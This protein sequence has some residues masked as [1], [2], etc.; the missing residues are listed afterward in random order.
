M[1]STNKKWL[2]LA[3]LQ[4]LLVLVYAASPSSLSRLEHA[5]QDWHARYIQPEHAFTDPRITLIDIDDASL[6]REGRWPWPRPQ[7]ADLLESIQ[8]HNPALIGIDIL[9]PDDSNQDRRLGKAL[10]ADNITTSLVWSSVRL[11]SNGNFP[12]VATCSNNCNQLPKAKSW[13]SNI[14]AL[15][16]IEQAHISP[17][18][19]K[20][21]IVRSL[22]P[23]VCKQNSCVETLAL[24]LSRQLLGSEAKYKLT[25]QANG[26]NL[27]SEDGI[28]NLPL[29]QDTRIRIPWYSPNAGRVPWVSAAKVLNNEIPPRFL[30]GRVLILGSSAV[31]LHDKISTPLTANYPAVEAHARLLQGILDQHY[32]YH[33]PYS[34]LITWLYALTTAL[35]VSGLLIRRRLFMAV[36]L[37]A[38]ANVGW[39]LFVSNA[40]K[41]GQIWP[42]LPVI[43]SPM[44]SMGLLLPWIMLDAQDARDILQHQFRHYVAPQVME[45]IQ[46]HPEYIIGA[47]PERSVMTVLFADLRSF[48]AYAE[49]TPP[50]QLAHILQEIM[51][52]LTET[53]H[54]HGGTVDKYI[55][56]AIMAFW[57]A[58]MADREHAAHGVAAAQDLCRTMERLS[59]TDGM[60][61]LQLSVGINSGVVVVGE[62]GSS[63]RRSYTLL[64]APVN[65]AA[66]LEGA[67]RKTCHPILVGSGTHALLP[68][69][70]WPEPI[71]LQLSS[72]NAPVTAWPLDADTTAKPS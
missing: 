38:C 48:S 24:S 23:L 43:L 67:T 56:D 13:I 53:I 65:L 25:P 64:G 63:H 31:G 36:L 61:P 34:E 32:W 3:A 66:H 45:R 41:E 4:A 19:D 40:L 28:L 49:N 20:D 50:E 37:V 46:K 58:P 22:Y 68:H 35:L 71:K 57:G 5:I 69:Y 42:Q 47:E 15:S 39:L 17:E 21:G 52:R 72:H 55:G 70:H 54:R 12:S 16:A 27:S 9:F 11:P 14:P 60:P 2:A 51:D 8:S 1:Q 59:Q 29:S 44:L 6:A 18:T 10:R 7:I 33:T 30:E 62:F 26:W